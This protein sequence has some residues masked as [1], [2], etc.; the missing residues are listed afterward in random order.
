[1]C[2]LA[3][4]ALPS[5]SDH[6]SS[7]LPQTLSDWLVITQCHLTNV[8]TFIR[9]RVVIIQD[10][11]V[12]CKV[13]WRRHFFRVYLKMMEARRA[14]LLTTTAFLSN[15]LQPNH[16]CELPTSCFCFYPNCVFPTRASFSST[17]RG[18]KVRFPT[19]ALQRTTDLQ[20]FWSSHFRDSILNQLGNTRAFFLRLMKTRSASSAALTGKCMTGNAYIKEFQNVRVRVK[21]LG[22]CITVSCWLRK[23]S[24]F[25]IGPICDIIWSHISKGQNKNHP[26]PHAVS[27]FSEKWMHTIAT[28]VVGVVRNGQDFDEW[29][30][31]IQPVCCCV[32]TFFCGKLCIL[33]YMEAV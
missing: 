3:Y 17:W 2:K 15:L 20:L 13:V 18:F 8:T 23:G 14:M 33:R 22:F 21:E 1:M 26:L 11:G 9:H 32:V 29:L 5:R 7:V 31:D 30:D 10:S 24:N 25:I 28:L 6:F 19:S 4:F 16:R 12:G 27:V